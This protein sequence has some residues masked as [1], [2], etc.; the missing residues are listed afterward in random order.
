LELKVNE[1]ICVLA[2]QEPGSTLVTR[3]TKLHLRE[4][5]VLRAD[6]L[7][8]E[9]PELHHWAAPA[10]EEELTLHAAQLAQLM[11]EEAA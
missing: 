11:A 6:E 9:Y 1:R 8:R 10:T 2:W 3:A 5:A 7:N 4:D